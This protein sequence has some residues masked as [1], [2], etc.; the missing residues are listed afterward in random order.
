M[1][2]LKYGVT[3]VKKG[4]LTLGISMKS[5]K[6]EIICIVDDDEVYQFSVTRTI[7]AANIVKKILIFS[8]GEEVFEFLQDNIS[9]KEELPDI[10]FLD[11][12][13]PYMD[14]WEF[15]DYYTKIKPN[16]PKKITVYL[17]SSS[18]SEKDQVKAQAI[19]DVSD[20]IVKPITIE[21]FRTAIEKY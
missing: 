13:M 18:V 21:D 4:Y 3:F 16:L 1:Y 5:E 9:K 11:I 15:L 14:G 6:A 8:D 17:V 20:Y 7:K 19:S 12:N 10:I 2:L